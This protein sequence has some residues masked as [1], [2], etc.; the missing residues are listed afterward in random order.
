M[1]Y[2][3][4]RTPDGTLGPIPDVNTLTVAGLIEELQNHIA[5]DPERALYPV[6]IVQIGSKSARLLPAVVACTG[7][8]DPEIGGPLCVMVMAL[9]APR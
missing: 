4:P 9:R 6:E 1:A 3:T 8:S 5:I 7:H 2:E